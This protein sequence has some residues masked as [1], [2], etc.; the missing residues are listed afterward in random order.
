MYGFWTYRLVP[1][2]EI[3]DD[4]ELRSPNRCVISPNSVAFGAYYVKVVRQYFLQ[5]K[6]G[7]RI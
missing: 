5:R 2:S 7:Q 6:L 4:L 3:L 1:N